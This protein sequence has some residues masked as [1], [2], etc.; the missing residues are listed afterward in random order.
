MAKLE[1]FKT[2]IISNPKAFRIKIDDK[3]V[4]T[5]EK[6]RIPTSISTN[7]KLSM[8]VWSSCHRLQCLNTK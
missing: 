7:D 5:Q 6:Y 1:D 8:E 2:V 3:I 4:V